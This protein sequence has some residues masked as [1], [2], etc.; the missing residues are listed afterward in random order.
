MESSLITWVDVEG[1]GDAAL[2]GGLGRLFGLHPLALEDVV[3]AH[4][5]AKVELYGDQLFMVARKLTPA[6]DTHVRSAQVSIFVGQQYVLTFQ[7]EAGVCFEPVRQRI[8]K[9]YGMFVQVARI[10]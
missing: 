1:L 4:Q 10:I 5:R 2:I 6:A 8:R 3:N 7:E 9:S